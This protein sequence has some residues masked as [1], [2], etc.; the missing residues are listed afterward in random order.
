VNLVKQTAQLIGA[1]TMNEHEWWMLQQLL[2]GRDL[3]DC[4]DYAKNFL[5]QLI[6]ESAEPMYRINLPVAR[7]L[8]A[9]PSIRD[10]I[11]VQGVRDY[12]EP[13]C[14]VLNVLEAMETRDSIDAGAEYLMGIVAS[15]HE[16]L[17]P[18]K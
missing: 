8:L 15:I 17:E 10:K 16:Q 13:R 11:T 2:E 4:R 1:Q 9:I 12:C 6:A 14:Y 18:R 5:I 7:R 3:D